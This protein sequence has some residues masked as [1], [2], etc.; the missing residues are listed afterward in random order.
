MVLT[1]FIKFMRSHDAVTLLLGFRIFYSLLI[2]RF[3]FG[4]RYYLF[5]S[6]LIKVFGYW[7]VP[8]GCCVYGRGLW[9]RGSNWM[10]GFD[11]PMLR[12]G[13]WKLGVLLSLL[14]VHQFYVLFAASFDLIVGTD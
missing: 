8:K 3:P 7:F 12:H 5:A 11:N 2:N 9:E 10:L 13:V 6:N 4:F 14:L 1:R